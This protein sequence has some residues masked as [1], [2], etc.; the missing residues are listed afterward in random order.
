MNVSEE[1]KPQDISWQCKRVLSKNRLFFIPFGCHFNS[2]ARYPRGRR[3]TQTNA[4]SREKST[5]EEVKTCVCLG[6]WKSCYSENVPFVYFPIYSP[7]GFFL[8]V[9][10]EEILSPVKNGRTQEKINIFTIDFFP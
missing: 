2:G 5:D 6:C 4:E 8:L 3:E 7:N 10:P 1:K 9:I